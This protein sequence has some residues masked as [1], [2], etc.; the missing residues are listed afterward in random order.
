MTDRMKAR[1]RLVVNNGVRI[2]PSRNEEV[3]PPVGF[4]EVMAAIERLRKV[5]STEPLEGDSNED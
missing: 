2:W 1:L 5:R 3:L 4:D